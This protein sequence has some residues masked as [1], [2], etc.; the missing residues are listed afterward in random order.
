MK[1]VRLEHLTKD[2]G[3]HKGIFDISLDINEG[4]VFGF[5]GPNGAGKTTTMRH[6][7][8]FIQ[9]QK[10]KSS[11]LNLDCWAQ[12]KEIQKHL[13]YL[14]AEIAFP[15]NMTGAQLIRHTTEIRGLTSMT[16]T[17]ML[18]ERFEL[19]PSAPIKRM[20]KGM[21]QKVGIICAFMH[22]PKVL[23]LDEPTTGLDPLMQSVFVELIKEEKR[24]GKSILMSSHLFEEIEG[25][26]DQI[27][28]V[29]QGRLI[30]MIDTLSMNFDRVTY[31]VE[32]YDQEEFESFQSEGFV[33]RDILK[34]D[35]RITI[36]IEDRQI[37]DLLL[38]LSKRQVK[39]IREMKNSLEENFMG[40]YKG[41]NHDIQ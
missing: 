6:L 28:I 16:K 22:D 25:T 20:S 1:T 39:S 21:K 13:G 19:D 17:N 40:F 23:I 9:P 7:L 4:E 29:K 5:L 26:C 30:S 38:S 3:N 34:E 2:Y 33:Y 15:A 35:L 24:D 36:D 12:S 11:I 37:N 14:P 31:K 10:G 32:F 18:L 8:G 41:D 27:G